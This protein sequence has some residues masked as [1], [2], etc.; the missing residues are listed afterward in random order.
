[1]PKVKERGTA[2]DELEVLLTIEF[3]LLVVVGV[4]SVGV[5]GADDWVHVASSIRMRI[6]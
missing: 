1:M 4:V 3:E 2:V 6:D 5:D